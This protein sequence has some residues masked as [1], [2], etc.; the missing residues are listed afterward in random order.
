MIPSEEGRALNHRPQHQYKPQQH[1][2]R[3]QSPSPRITKPFASLTHTEVAA[4]GFPCKSSHPSGFIRSPSK[5]QG[6]SVHTRQQRFGCTGICV[7]YFTMVWVM[8]HPWMAGHS[9]YRHQHR[10]SHL[11]G[12]CM[13]AE[14]HEGT[15]TAC[16]SLPGW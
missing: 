6:T 1:T 4:Q 2:V 7:C 14:S 12:G 9:S 3:K 10:K 13:P 5:A 11:V 8:T 15:V 16:G